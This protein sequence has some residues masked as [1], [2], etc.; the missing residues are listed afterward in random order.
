M[1]D[2]KLK[3]WSNGRVAVLVRYNM[4]GNVGKGR[5]PNTALGQNP[6]KAAVVISARAKGCHGTTNGFSHRW[7]ACRLG[8]ARR[9]ILPVGVWARRIG[10]KGRTGPAWH[11]NRG[12]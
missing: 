3:A 7:L 11:D 10:K 6:Y 1:E 9:R 5:Q 12:G 4:T 8:S 2:F